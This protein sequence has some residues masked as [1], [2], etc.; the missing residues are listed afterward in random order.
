MAWTFNTWFS[1]ESFGV[2]R[3]VLIAAGAMAIGGGV[4]YWYE[5]P[6]PKYPAAQ[7]EAIILAAIIERSVVTGDGGAID[8]GAGR[9]SGTNT[10]Y[11][12]N[13]VGLYPSQSLWV[14]LPP[15]AEGKIP[16]YLRTI[17][18]ADTFWVR[19]NDT[20]VRG[21][22]E[23]TNTTMAAFVDTNEIPSTAW[24]SNVLWT[25]FA[26]NYAG[27]SST[28]WPWQA[29][30]QY[31]SAVY[32]YVATNHLNQ[33]AAVICALKQTMYPNWWYSVGS[34]DDPAPD[35]VRTYFREFQATQLGGSQTTLENYLWSVTST[36][37]W[38][39][40]GPLSPNY[41]DVAFVSMS[42]YSDI[43][44]NPYWGG[45]IYQYSKDIQYSLSGTPTN[46]PASVCAWYIEPG[47][48]YSTNR[49]QTGSNTNR[50]RTEIYKQR[51]G[52][53]KGA[54][55]VVGTTNILAFYDQSTGS[56]KSPVSPAGTNLISQS[57]FPAIPALVPG[58]VEEYYCGWRPVRYGATEGYDYLL[59]VDWAFNYLTNAAA[60]WP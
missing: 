40:L 14:G 29:A 23:H 54:M 28:A 6:Q 9:F 37:T 19:S 44:G 34:E 41:H 11:A 26:P 32:Q 25:A 27:F 42:R 8:D 59:V 10:T 7:D 57:D 56:T 13:A 33:T 39:D 53:P 31:Q 47:S 52:L 2:T 50:W 17:Y 20:E 12:T 45:Y 43:G 30:T 24:W 58:Q 3:S 38:S 4:L 22:G 18:G 16:T 55:G 36:S 21:A 1:I 35:T 48:V 51:D 46:F 49:T 15:A 5:R 60:F